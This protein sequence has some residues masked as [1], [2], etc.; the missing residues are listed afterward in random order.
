MKQL[1]V[2]TLKKKK[3]AMELDLVLIFLRQWSQCT[4]NI[5]LE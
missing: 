2:H 3:A 1:Q 5:G 4:V